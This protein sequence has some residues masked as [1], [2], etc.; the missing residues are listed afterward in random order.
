M[1]L[2]PLKFDVGMNR[3]GREVTRF[4][5]RITRLFDAGWNHYISRLLDVG[6]TPL[7]ARLNASHPYSNTRF[8]RGITWLGA[9][10]TGAGITGLLE[11]ERKTQCREK[12][13]QCKNDSIRYRK[14]STWFK[15]H[16]IQHGNYSIR[17]G[18]CS[19]WHR[20]DLNWQ[21]NPCLKADW[22]SAVLH[23]PLASVPKV[24]RPI[25]LCHHLNL[26]QFMQFSL[27]EHK[28]AACA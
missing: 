21:K 12:R 26:V 11:W 6:I 4:G 9:G 16:P 2:E 13:P 8:G 28:R 23:F 7:G 15:N 18:N 19:I 3:F 5:A 24:T 1:A 10:I 27:V 14:N 20:S 17:Y 22:R 25:S